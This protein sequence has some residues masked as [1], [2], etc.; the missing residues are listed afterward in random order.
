[1]IRAMDVACV[2]VMDW[3]WVGGHVLGL[4]RGIL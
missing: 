4:G 3:A 1:L 2:R